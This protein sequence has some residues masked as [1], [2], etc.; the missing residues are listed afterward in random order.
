VPLI[1]T[2]TTPSLAGDGATI[3]AWR[4]PLVC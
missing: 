1:D 4:A 2:E 3:E